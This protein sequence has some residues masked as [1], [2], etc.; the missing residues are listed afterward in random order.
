[1]ASK[2]VFDNDH[3]IIGGAA[4]INVAIEIKYDQR[5]VTNLYHNGIPV[6][7]GIVGD[8]NRDLNVKS[9]DEVKVVT[10]IADINQMTNNTEVVVTFTGGPNK[11]IDVHSELADTGDI[12]TYHLNYIMF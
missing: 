7:E 12:V 4:M 6:A 1:M 10:T 8:F 5:G 3:Y 11:K 2:L 9:G